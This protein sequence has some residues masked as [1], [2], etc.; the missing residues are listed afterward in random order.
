MINPMPR[1]L[2][3]LVETEPVTRKA[4]RFALRGQG[5]SV[6]EAAT[7]TQAIAKAHAR[8][9]DAVILSLEL[10][11]L[12]GARVL[13]SLREQLHMPIIAVSARVGERHLIRVLD[14][15]ASDYVLKPIREGELMARLRAALRAAQSSTLGKEVVV[16]ELRLDLLRHRVLLRGRE[17]VLTPTEFRLLHV[18][19]TEAGQVLSNHVLLQQVWGPAQARDVQYVRVYM[20]QLRQKLEDDPEHPKRLVTTPGIGYR[21][22]RN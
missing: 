5:Y 10:P 21:L 13:A 4:L 1:T 17:V 14:A 9:P 15:G 12:D 20:S 6:C 19:A 11:D 18:L 16:G 7:G 8:L 22:V 2:I 3:L